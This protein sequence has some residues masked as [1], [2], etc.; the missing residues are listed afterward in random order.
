MSPTQRSLKYLREQGY[1][2]A[3]TEKFNQ[4][5]RVRQD[6]WGFVDILALKEN[7]T[8]GVQCTSASNVSARVRK[9]AES[10]TVAN[11]RKAGWKIHVHG[12]TKGQRGAPRIVDVS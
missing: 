7:E 6:R 8:L 5:A 11:V 10:D 4:F 1:M 2:A 9:I 12:W 3:V